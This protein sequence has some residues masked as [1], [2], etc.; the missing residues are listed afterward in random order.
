MDS[1]YHG[2]EKA[3]GLMLRTNRVGQ[4]CCDLHV[5]S[6]QKGTTVGYIIFTIRRRLSILIL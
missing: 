4:D 1:L 6:R 2:K 5:S 3:N